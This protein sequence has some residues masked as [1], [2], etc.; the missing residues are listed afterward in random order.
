MYAEILC[1]RGDPVVNATSLISLCSSAESIVD[2]GNDKTSPSHYYDSSSSS[3]NT[4][5]SVQT[6][7]QCDSG[8]P[9]VD[10]E[11]T[12]TNEV[13]YAFNDIACK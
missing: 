1:P 12:V 2:S 5:N 3:S 6:H 8:N 11:V 9:I 4:G 10:S 13:G 7:Q